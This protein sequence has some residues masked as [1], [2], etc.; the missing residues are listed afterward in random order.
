MNFG[1]VDGFIDARGISLIRDA[2]PGN[3]TVIPWCVHTAAEVN[4]V[5]HEMSDSHNSKTPAP[6][7][8]GKQVNL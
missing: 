4:T 6:E 7:T 8:K 3:Y 5:E 1:V 2:T